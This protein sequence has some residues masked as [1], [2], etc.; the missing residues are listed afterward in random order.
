[1][2]SKVTIHRLPLNVASFFAGIGGIDLGLQNAGL[3]LRFQCEI[4]HFCTSILERHWPD[5]KRV[6]DIRDIGG[7]QDV[8]KAELWCAGFPCQDVSLAR[9]RRRAGLNGRH[10]GLFYEFARLL[11][12]ARPPMFILENVPGLLSSHDGRDFGIVLS[13]LAELGYGVA[14]RVLDSQYFGVPQSRRR[15]YLAGYRGDPSRAASLLFEPECSEGHFKKNGCSGQ[16][17]VSPFKEIVGDPGVERPVVQR[18]GYC[19]AAT[20]GRH[21]GTDWSRTYVAYADAVRRLTPLEAE[22]LQGFPDG[23]TIPEGKT[24]EEIAD[25]DSP[26]YAALGNAV[27]VPV[28][29]WVGSRLVH[30]HEEGLLSAFDCPS[31]AGVATVGV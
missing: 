13:T 8:P 29:T 17:S 19:L 31:V 30:M 2:V 25:L 14:W 21:T 12:D 20:S 24:A 18:V 23:W 26:R 27:S 4:D 22:R 5:V 3:A 28:A 7:G 11:N 15:L 1:M 10:T 16:K 6:G 9:A